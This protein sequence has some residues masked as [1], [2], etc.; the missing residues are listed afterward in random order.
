MC[1]GSNL[2]SAGFPSRPGV[3]R[4]C[5]AHGCSLNN[6][7]S[8]PSFRIVEVEQ[9][10]KMTSG[11]LGIVFGP[12][13]MRPRPTEATISLSSLVDYPHQ[14]RIVEALIVFYPVILEA[15]HTLK[16]DDRIT[17]NEVWEL[18]WRQAGL[19]GGNLFASSL[20]DTFYI[21]FTGRHKCAIAW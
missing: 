11:N 5:P 20:V 13:L 15:N 7:F 2:A 10:N 17:G 12:T 1:L 9:D 4:H 8:P 19:S 18:L 21:Q 6:A 3:V 16:E 14:A